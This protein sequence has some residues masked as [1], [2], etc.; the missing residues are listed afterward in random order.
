MKKQ[1]RIVIL[2][3]LVTLV[4]FG[5]TTTNAQMDS[6][7][8]VPVTE[9]LTD[10][11]TSVSTML[12]TT[13]SLALTS[14]TFTYS[15]NASNFLGYATYQCCANDVPQHVLQCPY[16]VIDSFMARAGQDV[17]ITYSSTP[18][19]FSDF[20]FLSES[21]WAEW[22]NQERNRF[23]SCYPPD[24]YTTASLQVTSLTIDFTPPSDGTYFIL[25]NYYLQYTPQNTPSYPNTFSYPEFTLKVD[26]F[27]VNANVTLASY[28]TQYR[29]ET[30]AEVTES[31]STIA[32][33]A[34]RPVLWY[35]AG[36]ILVAALGVVLVLPRFRRKR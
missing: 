8:T 13:T 27:L 25:A 6:T 34:I 31:P 30:S 3:L 10:T 11:L 4:S 29:T 1:Q 33:G 32:F 7:T 20:Y 14:V 23:P 26:G 12:S 15:L 18:P 9:T 19:T 36:I 35:L 28:L 5:V 17:H 16:A 24:G 22:I 2:I 21:Q